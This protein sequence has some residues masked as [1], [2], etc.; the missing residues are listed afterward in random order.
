MEE[1]RGVAFSD[2]EQLQT[3][4]KSFVGCS[5]E[6]ATLAYGGGVHPTFEECSFGEVGWHFNDAGLRTV[7]FLQMIVN[8]PGGRGFV[9]D[10]FQPG[11]FITE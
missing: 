10:L 2:G 1:I 11:K 3:D 9:A 5:F 6:K 7:Q 4:G 8:S